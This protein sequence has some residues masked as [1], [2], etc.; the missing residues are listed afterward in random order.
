[1][2]VKHGEAIM[3]A[4]TVAMSARSD[5]MN[6]VSVCPGH[7]CV[8][9]HVENVNFRDDDA[10]SMKTMAVVPEPG[11]SCDWGRVPPA[12]CPAMA[13]LCQSHHLSSP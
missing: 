4:M 3:S 1:M 9:I 8:H 6:H 2:I 10:S 11:S 13:T 7:H 5:M 12:A